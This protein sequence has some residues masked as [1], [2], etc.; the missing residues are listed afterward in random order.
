MKLVTTSQEYMDPAM[1]ENRGNHKTSANGGNPVSSEVKTIEVKNGIWR[2]Y[3]A[4]DGLPPGAYYC[5]LQDRQGYLWLGTRHGL[6]RYD[7]VR[8]TTYTTEDGLPA[9]SVG[10]IYEDSRGRL[11]FG[12]DEGRMRG[13]VSYAVYLERSRR[14]GE[15]F[16]TYTPE[17]RLVGGFVMSICE[18]SQGRLWFGTNSGVFCYDGQRFTDYTTE[19]G[20][21]HNNVRAIYEDRQGRLWFS[22]FGGVSCYDGQRF[23]NYTTED[24]LA[25]N[26]GRAIHEDRQGRLW[27]GT[28]GGVSCYDGQRFI[29]YTTEDG[30]AHNNVIPIYEDRQGRLW[31]GT[32]GGGVCC[33]DGRSFTA[34]T[35]ADG[36]LDNRVYDI[37]QDRE[38]SFWFLHWHSGMTRFDPETTRLL[39]TSTVSN[40]L[41]Q[42]SEGALWFGDDN[43]LCRLHKGEQRCQTFDSEVCSLLEDSRGRFWVGTEWDGLYC[44]DSTD[45]VWEGKP[46]RFATEA[47][48]V[49]RRIWSV[50]E[51]RDGIIWVGTAGSPGC[52]CRVGGSRFEAIQTPHR[53]VQR[54]LEDNYG[55]IWMGGFGGGGLSYYDPAK[56]HAAPLHNYTMRHGL[57]GDSVTSIVED[58]AG[59]LWIG[60]L[61]GLCCFDGN[62]FIPYGEETLYH[63][64]YQF[65]AKDVDGQLWFGTLGNGVYRYDG[66]HF[67]QLSKAD[68]LPSNSVNGFVPQ[69]DGSMIIGTRGIVHYRPTATEPPKIEI[70]EV[71]AD[72]IYP[73]PSSLQLTTTGADLVTIAYSGLGLSTHRMR[74]SYILEGYA[75]ALGKLEQNEERGE[76]QDTWDSQVRYEN[77]PVGEYTFKVIAINRDLVPS[78]TPA[79][80]KLRV[81]P[82]PRDLMVS[83]LEA[84]LK[85]RNQQLAFLQQEVGRKYHFENIIGDSEAIEWVRAMMARAIDSGLNVLITGDTG[86]G[87]EL[88]AKGIHYNSSRKDK[89]LIT[90]NCGAIQK[91]LVASELFGHRKGAF[92]GA[93]ED[94]MGLFEVAQG[95]TVALDEMGDMPQDAQIHLLRVL[96]ERKVQRLGEYELRD[97]DVRVIAMT[98]RDLLEEV[99]Q[100]RFREDLYYRLNGFHIY[101][102]PLRKRTDD[103]PPLAKHFYQEACRDQGKELGGFAPGVIDMLVAYPWP[104]NVRELRNEIH[105]ACVL[106]GDGSPIQIHHFSPQITK[107]ESLIQEVLSEQLGL[108]ASLEHLRRRMVE[109]ALRETGGNRTQAAKRLRMDTA[110][111]RHLIKRLGIKA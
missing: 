71:V 16:I 104:G 12:A 21:A 87:K 4:T 48:D 98:N 34:Y 92:T 81:V 49:L 101:I 23:T 43:Q 54:L 31:F 72:Q 51:A 13:G 42:A 90:F 68:G 86:T 44:Y 33:L 97:V 3:D 63:G 45:A 46:K 47:E 56:G 105:R 91:E 102:P 32:Q 74:Y 1:N 83:E 99:E 60:T 77:L 25:H 75:Q 103:I 7:G 50:I 41:I 19:D 64:T 84:D 73:H 70:R 11:W 28:F 8:F 96:E 6:C 106:A 66:R 2:T 79:T 53:V 65:S 18:D 36:L 82:D 5:L 80:L 62:Q 55:R 88:V 14:D 10:S 27:F 38:G 78:E 110:N 29:N 76:W 89:P 111:L 17:D 61:D 35:A 52:L 57:P 69:P 100:K 108:S 20:L 58:D 93:I 30:L 109:D 94:K 67:Q 9:N 95:G 39:T 85:V 107:G 15:R 37:L 26:D 24:G 40:S 22:T 59:R